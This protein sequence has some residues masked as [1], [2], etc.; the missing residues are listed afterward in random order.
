MANPYEQIARANK[1]DR[2]V[3]AMVAASIDSG[4][5]S[6]M[7]AKD[8]LVA[9]NSVGVRPPSVV[10]IEAVITRLVQIESQGRA[11]A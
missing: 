5:A 8:W 6:A 2:L 11:A 4:L 7:D 10:T 1:V 9:A 3:A